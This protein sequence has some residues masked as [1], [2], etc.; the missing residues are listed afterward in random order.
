M[1]CIGYTAVTQ[2]GSYRCPR[3]QA[4]G[5]GRDRCCRGLLLRGL[6]PASH[7]S[8]VCCSPT[9]LRLRAHEKAAGRTI[10]RPL[11]RVP[12]PRRV[13]GTG[14]A[15]SLFYPQHRARRLLSRTPSCDNGDHDHGGLVAGA[16]VEY[17]LRGAALQR[18][19]RRR[20][21]LGYRPDVNLPRWPARG[22]W[23][24]PPMWMGHGVGD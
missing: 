22:G 7:A 8:H 11:R 16:T 13:H 6:L 23:M 20:A 15:V 5:A 12:L 10:G 17:L 3:A 18:L 2:V 1:T 19:R 21:G 24:A 14:R 9:S 4:A